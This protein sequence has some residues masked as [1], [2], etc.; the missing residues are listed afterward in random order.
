MI[1]E[2]KAF[3]QTVERVDMLIGPM[4][5][6]AYEALGSMGNDVP[7]ACLSSKPRLIHDYFKQLFAQVT[8]PPIESIRESIVMSLSAYI[9]PRANL[10]SQVSAQ[11]CNLLYLESPVLKP[12]EFWKVKHMVHPD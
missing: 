6:E 5:K 7:L 11:T 3:G 9:G 10:C 12:E 1:T 8:N 2:F 4:A